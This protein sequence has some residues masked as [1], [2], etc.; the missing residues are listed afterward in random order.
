MKVENLGENEFEIILEKG[1]EATIKQPNGEL[2]YFI[3]SGNTLQ[4]QSSQ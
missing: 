3:K 1:D 2:P 4:I